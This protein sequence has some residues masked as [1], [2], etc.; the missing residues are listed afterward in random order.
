MTTKKWIA[1]LMTSVLALSGCGKKASVPAPTTPLET[2]ECVM[3]SIKDLD[4]ETLNNYSDNYIQTYHNW[5]GVPVESEYRTFNELLQP[6]S[7][8]SSRYQSAYKLDQK[9]MENLTWKISDV[10]EKDNAAEIDMEITNIDMSLAMGNYTAQILENVL[11]S[12]GIGITQFAKEMSELATSKDSLISIIDEL[13][14]NDRSTINVTV[15]AY[16]DNGQWKIHLTQDFINAF[17]GN[18]YADTYAEDIEQRIA[19]LEE[20]IERKADQWAESFENKVNEW[21]EQFE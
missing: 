17:S 2:V 7:K 8:R 18:M 20:Q 13:D 4:M 15:S 6:R 21:S 1:F 3:E 10:R 16:Q 9:I 12:P 11:E 5:I 19:E 14:D